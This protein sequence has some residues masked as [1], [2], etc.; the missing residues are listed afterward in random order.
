MLSHLKG[1]TQFVLELEEERI[2][3]NLAHVRRGEVGRKSIKVEEH[4]NPGHCIH[5]KI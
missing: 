4:S 3:D 5:R 1:K 2:S